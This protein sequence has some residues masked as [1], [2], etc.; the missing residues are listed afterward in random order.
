MTTIPDGHV[1]FHVASAEDVAAIKMHSEYRCN[2]L[3]SEGFIHC[4]ERN[5]LAGVLQRY[6]QGVDNLK[7]LVID[8]QRLE[9]EL[10]V[11]NTT[12]GSELFPHIYGPINI[13]ALD[14][15]LDFSLASNC[16]QEITA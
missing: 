5:Q 9:N 12:G 14:T 6:Y 8:P 16:R 4:C 13:D 2:S 10:V 3:S 15:I 1:I 11:E 7:L